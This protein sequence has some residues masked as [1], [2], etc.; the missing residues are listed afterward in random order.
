MTRTQGSV[1]SSGYSNPQPA[2][3]GVSFPNAVQKEPIY[4]QQPQTTTYVQQISPKTVTTTYVNSYQPIDYKEPANLD[5]GFYTRSYGT[6]DYHA[7]Q[8]YPAPI[9]Q[10][11][12]SNQIL[13]NTQQFPQSHVVHAA[14]AVALGHPSRILPNTTPTPRT[15]TCHLK[16]SRLDL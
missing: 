14:Y 12:V 15:K 1:F 3:L 10:Q 9:S 13:A 11:T 2:P 16:L 5:D 6:L 8:Q 7:Q 4:Q